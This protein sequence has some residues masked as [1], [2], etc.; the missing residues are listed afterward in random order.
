MSYVRTEAS[1]AWMR[2]PWNCPRC[3][4]TLP[5]GGRGTHIR[6]CGRREEHFWSKV[7]KEAPGGCWLYRGTISFEGYGYVNIGAGVR[8]KQWQAHRFAWSLLKGA[9]PKGACVLHKCDVRNCV[10]PEHLY[11]GDRADNAKDK[12]RRQRDISAALTYQQAA[13]IKAALANWKRGMNKE[14]A[15]K[16]GVSPTVICSIKRGKTYQHVTGDFAAN[17]EAKK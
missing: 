9:I 13:E 3:K 5:A 10:N 12:I 15:E 7:D 11:L 1:M 8:R 14:L 2:Q 6:W 17:G 4:Q 16:Y